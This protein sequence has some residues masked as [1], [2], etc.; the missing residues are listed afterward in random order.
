MRV[1]SLQAV[2]KLEVIR[3]LILEDRICDKVP[4]KKVAGRRCDRREKEGK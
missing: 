3:K 4:P 1:R 2:E